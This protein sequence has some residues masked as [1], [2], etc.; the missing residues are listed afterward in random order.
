MPIPK[1]TQT[2][3][4]QRYPRVGQTREAAC[5][6]GENPFSTQYRSYNT[7]FEEFDTMFLKDSEQGEFKCAVPLTQM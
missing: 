2:Q 4:A 3:L 5:F 6:W 7:T 1:T